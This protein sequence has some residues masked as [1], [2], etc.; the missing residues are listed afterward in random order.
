MSCG[1]RRL[2]VLLLTLGSA[3]ACALFASADARARGASVSTTFTGRAFAWVSRLGPKSGK[4]YVYV[5]GRYATTVNLYSATSRN[6]RIVFSRSFS[7]SAGHSV[8]IFVAGTSRH[9]RVDLDAFLI[10]R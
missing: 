5:D 1:S 7:T 10:V 8:W 4:A 6:R 2:L 3:S 9:P